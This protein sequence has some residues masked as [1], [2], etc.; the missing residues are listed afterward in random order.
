MRGSPGRCGQGIQADLAGLSRADWVLA[1][2]GGVVDRDDVQ[3]LA[4]DG[5][6]A[7]QDGELGGGANEV[8]EAADHAACDASTR[9]RSPQP[10]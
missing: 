1:G 10:S 2:L 5:L 7:F 4:G 8:G 9:R 3:Q 6:T